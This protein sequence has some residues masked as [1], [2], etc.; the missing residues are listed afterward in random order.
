MRT[1]IL[2]MVCITFLTVSFAAYAMATEKNEKAESNQKAKEKKPKKEFNWPD[3][4]PKK[5]SGTADLDNYILSCDT[6]WERIRTYSDSIA[7]F[8]L[9]TPEW[10]PA[11]NIKVVRIVDEEGNPKNFSATL[12]QDFD[13]ALAGTNI[14]LDATNMTLQTANATSALIGNPLLAL[15]YTKCLAGGP[16]IVKLAFN[17]VKEIVDA[18]KTQIKQINSMKKSQMEGSTDQAIILP[19]EEGEIPDPNKIVNFEDIDLGSSDG[20]I[21]LN[22]LDLDALEKEEIKAPK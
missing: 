6:L 10:S 16:N 1:I 21:D 20:E 19:I 11:S 12:K 17:E 14:L 3:I 8:R 15:S 13:L 5:L 9:D 7:F 4:R 18:T 2:R 22:N